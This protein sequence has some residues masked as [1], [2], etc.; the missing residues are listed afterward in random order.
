[1]SLN[2]LQTYT[3]QG[4]SPVEAVIPQALVPDKIARPALPDLKMR[5]ISSPSTNGNSVSAGNSA[6]FSL[7]NQGMIK[8]QSLY[9]KCTITPN[10]SCNFKGGIGAQAIINRVTISSGGVAEVLPNYSTYAQILYRNNTNL[11]YA[12][13]DAVV[14]EGSS[15]NSPPSGNDL[16]ILPAGGLEVCLPILSNIFGSTRAFPTFMLNQSLQVELSFNSVLNSVYLAGG[17]PTSLT[18]SNMSLIYECIYPGQEY[19]NMCRQKALERGGLNFQFMSYLNHQFNTLLGASASFTGGVGKSSVCAV[20]HACIPTASF[21]GGTLISSIVKNGQSAQRL[22]LDGQ[23]ALN[24][25]ITSSAQNLI[26]YQKA[27]NSCFDVNTTIGCVPAQYDTLAYATGF[28]TR[29][30]NEN[31]ISGIPV[32]Q[33]Q[34]Q[35]TG[36]TADVNNYLYVLYNANCVISADGVLSVQA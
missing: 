23:L 20:L 16:T 10:V 6:F 25:D 31:I 3:V 9:L 4:G 26:E 5:C 12:T 34:Y 17:A 32:N 11:N 13:C 18:I 29:A 21:N 27:T 35:A 22:Y 30:F 2:A 24:Y 1:M 14:M 19:E 28:N 8:G 15:A 33:L 7:V 36:A